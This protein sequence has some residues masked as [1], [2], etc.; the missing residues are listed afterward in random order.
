MRVLARGEKHLYQL[1]WRTLRA[2]QR[3]RG[4]GNRISPLRALLASFTRVYYSGV[5]VL[6]QHIWMVMA[7]T[8]DVGGRE[9]TEPVI[10]PRHWGHKGRTNE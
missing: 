3:F 7:A 8:N 6:P 4:I 1:R 10:S 9:L 2:F 5:A